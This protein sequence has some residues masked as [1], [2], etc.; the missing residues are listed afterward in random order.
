MNGFKNHLIFF[1]LVVAFAG[2]A[3]SGG[4]KSGAKV[5]ATK[6]TKSIKA[7]STRSVKSVKSCPKSIE[8]KEGTNWKELVEMANS[9][10]KAGNWAQ[11]ENL[12]NRLAKSEYL[13]PWGVYFLSLSAWEKK[14]YAR[15]LWMVEAALKKAPSTGLFYHQK[16]RILWEMKEIDAAVAA[17]EESLRLDPQNTEAHFLVGQVYLQ[18]LD[19]K[20]AVEHLEIVN[21]DRSRDPHVMDGLSY[22]YLKLGKFQ[23]ALDLLETAIAESPRRLDL[24]LR[25]ANILEIHLKEEEKA[26]VVYKRIRH[27]MVKRRLEGELNLSLDEKIKNLEVA[28]EKKRAASQKQVS[29][30]RAEDTEGGVAK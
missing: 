14:D 3:S 17:F 19:Y 12:G 8:V 22:C 10:V 15:S 2:C 18:D 24:R 23:K 20:R 25:Q 30:N 9:C 29:L 16:G 6:Y 21:N 28:V 27:L 4:S 11:V 7:K 5:A 26:L 1:G 13:S